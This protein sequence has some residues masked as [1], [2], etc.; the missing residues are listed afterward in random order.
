MALA[1][2]IEQKLQLSV[3]DFVGRSVAELGITGSGKQKLRRKSA[4]P[5]NGIGTML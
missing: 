5:G 4:K 1:L 3:S 2:D